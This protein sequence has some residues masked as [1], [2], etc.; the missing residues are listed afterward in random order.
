MIHL[1][2]LPAVPLTTD[3]I[4]F[5]VEVMEVTPFDYEDTIIERCFNGTLRLSS[6]NEWGFSMIKDGK[7]FRLDEDELAEHLTGENFMFLGEITTLEGG[8]FGLTKA[9]DMQDYCEKTFVRY[10]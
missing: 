9:V 4:R 3:L 8:G 10:L 2:K 7:L 6:L 5:S 1:V